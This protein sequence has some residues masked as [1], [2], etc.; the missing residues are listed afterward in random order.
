MNHK[1]VQSYKLASSDQL[2]NIS[3]KKIILANNFNINRDELNIKELEYISDGLF[4]IQML[5]SQ[6][7]I[8]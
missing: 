8:R 3:K 4:N 6:A 7:K 1:F 2:N 5:Q